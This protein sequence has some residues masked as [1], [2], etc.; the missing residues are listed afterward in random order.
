MVGVVLENDVALLKE[1]VERGD[2]VDQFDWEACMTPLYCA[3]EEGHIGCVQ[4]LLK[5]GADV[6]KA[7]ED[8]WTPLQIACTRGHVQCVELIV[9]HPLVNVHSALAGF[10]ALHQAVWNGGVACAEVS[11]G[12]VIFKL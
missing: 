4:V 2:D 8:G 9:Q 1:M 11:E 10:S 7:C 3:A 6:N 5:G 12:E